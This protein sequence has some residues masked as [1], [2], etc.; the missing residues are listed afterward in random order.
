MAEA[1]APVAK[2][3]ISAVASQVVGNVLSAVMGGGTKK[4]PQAPSTPTPEMPVP[5]QNK[6]IQAQ[7]LLRKRQNAGRQSTI[8]TA[9][10][11][12][13]KLGG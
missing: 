3:V 12:A 1:A 4:A 5:N 9:L 6:A 11:G 10:G 13:D 7:S 8:L 2:T